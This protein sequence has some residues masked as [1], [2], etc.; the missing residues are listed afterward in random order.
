MF[1]YSNI[2]VSDLLFVKKLFRFRS[3]IAKLIYRL[4]S[5]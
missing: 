5:S 3:K 1:T 2:S 4:F